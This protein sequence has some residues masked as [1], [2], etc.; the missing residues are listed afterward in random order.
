MVKGATFI[1]DDKNTPTINKELKPSPP[2]DDPI[3]DIMNT[4][5]GLPEYLRKPVLEGRLKEFYTLSDSDKHE[6]VAG[7]LKAI[8][9]IEEE[10]ISV[11]VKTW[12]TVLCSFDAPQVVEMLRIYC[13]KLIESPSIIQKLQVDTVV[14]TFDE[15]K[16]LQ[17]EKL[18]DCL[19]EAILS[20]PNRN[21]I[22]DL[23]PQSG[24]K[25]LGMQ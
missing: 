8:P 22:I 13:L 15:M 16:N 1:V 17:K 2:I 11:L 6:I 19:K 4:L 3:Q 10:K 21:E 5:I 9:S 7:V 24:L 20:F 23:I 25:V 12:M 14:K 18:A